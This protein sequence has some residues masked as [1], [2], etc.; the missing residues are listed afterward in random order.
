M[1]VVYVEQ[2]EVP[3]LL[4]AG[5]SDHRSFNTAYKAPYLM[6]CHRTKTCNCSPPPRLI[7]S[8]NDTKWHIF[9]YLFLEWRRALRVLTT[10]LT[11]NF[12]CRDLN[13]SCNP[14]TLKPYKLDQASNTTTHLL[15]L[16]TGER[17]YV[18]CLYKTSLSLLSSEQHC[19]WIGDCD[20][21]KSV[22]WL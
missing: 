14:R 8:S 20:L 11:S 15:L 3:R 17:N 4:L 22:T 5:T 10:Y 18:K 9:C 1:F 19:P 13:F 16:E 12:S 7:M 21:G 6:I 2:Y